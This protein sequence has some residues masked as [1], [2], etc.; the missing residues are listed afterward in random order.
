[1]P[2]QVELTIEQQNMTALARAL[3]SEADGKL[4]RRD[5]LRALRATAD[6]PVSEAKARIRATP[7]R[8]LRNGV[9]LRN[10]VANSIKPVARLSGQ[11]TG[12]SIRQ[13]GTSQLRQFKMAGRRFNRGSFRRPVF[14]TARYVVQQGN[15]GWF[16]DPMKDA[17]PEAKEAVLGVIVDMSERIARRIRSTS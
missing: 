4:L 3:K 8:G 2:G 10:E 6:T 17:G 7:T 11:M 5:L 12:V 9:S 16:D 14:G 15:K 1:M 13:S